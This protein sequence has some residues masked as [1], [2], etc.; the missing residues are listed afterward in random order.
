MSLN[1]PRGSLQ[2]TLQDG[3]QEW[4]EDGVL[5]SFGPF[6]AGDLSVEATRTGEDM[7]AI[8]YQIG[9]SPCCLYRGPIPESATRPIEARVEWEANGEI[10]LYLNGKEVAWGPFNPPP[11][12]EIN[13]GSGTPILH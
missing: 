12:A 6:F 3:R 2:F 1:A 13:E 8:F 4:M 7:L 10:I 11:H 5:R 9:T